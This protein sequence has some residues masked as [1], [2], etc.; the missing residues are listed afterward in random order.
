ML[1][2]LIPTY[3]YIALDLVKSL[4]TQLE[5]QNIV[6]EL[7]C[8]DNGSNSRAN[9]ENERIN[10]IQNCYFSALKK[11]GG[12]SRVKNILAKKSIYPWLLFLFGIS[13]SM[14]LTR[15]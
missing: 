7:I 6:Y 11:D 14:P 2:I 13:I 4:H 9:I 12:R 5:E 3:N 8:F 1:S 10:N 15:H